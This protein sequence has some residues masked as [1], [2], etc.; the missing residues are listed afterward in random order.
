MVKTLFYSFPKDTASD[1]L[2]EPS[3]AKKPIAPALLAAATAKAMQVQAY[4]NETKPTVALLARVGS[5]VSEYNMHYTHLGFV[6]KDPSNTN[7]N[8]PKWGV[9]QLLNASGTNTSRIYEEGLINFLLDNLFKLDV[10][11]IIP[12]PDIQKK[13]ATVLTSNKV[14]SFHN[15]NYSMIAYPF[16]TKYQQSNQWV[17]E[18]L[19]SALFGATDRTTAQEYLKTTAYTPTLIP[20]SGFSKLGAYLFKKNV[21]FDDHPDHEAVAR[22]Y[23]VVT[24]DSVINYLKK[25]NLVSTEKEFRDCEKISFEPIS[26]SRSK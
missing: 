20:I 18:L 10:K 8:N 7:P 21:R 5:D 24:V 13:L 25:Q 16:S 3:Y 12:T 6:L 1:S 11:I 22:K 2:A 17:L 4:L 9:I 26:Q 15:K 23:S 14:I 19:A